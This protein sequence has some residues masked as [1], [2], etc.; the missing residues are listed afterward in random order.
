M[1]RCP[2]CR[3]D[4]YD[5]ALIFCL[6]DGARLLEGPAGVDEQAT[7]KMYAPSALEGATK[8]LDD[9]PSESRG[10]QGP[11]SSNRV[12]RLRLILAGIALLIAVVSLYAVF[13]RTP[14]SPV[15][16]GSFRS[17]DSAAYEYYLRAKIDASSQN[18]ERNESAIKILQEVVAA[19][20]GFAPAYADLAR[21]YGIRANMFAPAD[22]QKK[23]YGEARVAVEKALA[24][25]PNLAT[26]H[27]VRGAIIWNQLDR[28]PHEQSI[29]SLKRAIALDPN[30][31]EAHH[32]LG[33]IYYHIGLFD[34]GEQELQRA[35]DINPSDAL[36]RFRVGVISEYRM[37]FE[38][39]L[40]VYKT[41][42]RDAYSAGV[43]RQMASVLFRL[44]RL[45]EASSIIDEVL[46]AGSDENGN[47]TSVRALMLAKA[48]E[49]AEAETTISRAIDI[50]QSFQH[51]HH[52]AYNI[53]SAYA[54]LGKRDD[55]LR[56][57]EFTADN[58]LPCYPLFERDPH[59]H[60]LRHDERFVSLMTRLKQQW[61]RHQ[62]AL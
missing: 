19:D 26:G 50:G 48:G 27:F 62:A 30:L 2:D 13:Y 18:R 1:K 42:P 4:Y 28:F 32:L 16:T 39:A 20:P 60:S 31:G 47:V 57:L 53:A 37:D 58:G 36:A 49:G 35:I 61:E 46:S 11:G 59:L 21:A 41:V 5:D 56:W 17:V 54:L 12:S 25:E 10:D 9:R 34:K 45:D 33:Q 55:A 3:R 23:L 24:L 52:A 14:S 7:A 15:P 43:N 22:E 38:K 44:G 51:F 6:D 40:S 29:R 8:V